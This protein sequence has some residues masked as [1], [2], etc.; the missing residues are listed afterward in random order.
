MRAFVALMLTMLVSCTD[1]ASSPSIDIQRV[2]D[3]GI[4]PRIVLDEWGDTHMLFFR[5]EFPDSG[6]YLGHLYYTRYDNTQHDWLPAARVSSEP[7]NYKDQIYRANF[8]VG[9]EGSVH[10]VWFVDRPGRFLLTR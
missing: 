8:A 6:A 4:H 9:G 7:F 2:P 1:P 10:V 5:A 3:N